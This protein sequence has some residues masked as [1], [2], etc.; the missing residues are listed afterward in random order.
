MHI[1]LPADAT[2]TTLDN[3]LRDIWLECCGHL[4]AFRIGGE[5]YESM[6]DRSWR[7]NNKPM[8]GVKLGTILQPGQPFTHEYDF[9]STTELKLRMISE[10]EAPAKGKNVQVLARNLPPDIRC[11]TCGQPAAWVCTECAWG[12]DQGWYCNKCLQE[13]EC[14]DEMALPV[15]NSPRVGVCGYEG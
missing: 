10:R 12:E 15:V 8:R 9:G 4:S 7:M 2:L 11:V 3:F 14:G 13:H 6:V 5:T 1:E